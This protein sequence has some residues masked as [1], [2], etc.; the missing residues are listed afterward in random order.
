MTFNRLL[1]AA[2]AVSLLAGAAPLAAQAQAPAPAPAAPATPAAPAAPAA[3]LV[4]NGDM[5]STLR[6]S[7]DFSTFMKALDA[8]NL[9]G[10]IQSRPNM[11]VFAP[12]NAAF[13]ALPAGK[14]DAL[15]ADKPALQKLMLHHIINA[16]VPASK[17]KGSRGPVPSGAGD[18]IV[19][20]GSGEQLK[21]D[22]ANIIQSDVMASNGTIH[23][24][25]QVLMAGS[26]PATLPEQAAEPAP[27]PKKN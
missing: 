7:P 18:P 24:V 6:Q 16:P 17:I 21:A 11:T 1:T 14:L 5:A 20:D 26:V 23:V 4:A 19:L 12:T 2:A 22:N 8:T 27:E 15:M 3:K 10:L 25:D 9:A 13:A